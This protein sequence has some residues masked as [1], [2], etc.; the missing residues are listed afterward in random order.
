MLAAI[1]RSRSRCCRKT[2]R[3]GRS[4]ERVVGW[5][6]VAIFDGL[7]GTGGVAHC[8]DVGHPVA[9]GAPDRRNGA[10]EGVNEQEPVAS[11]SPCPPDDPDRARRL[12]WA[13]LLART[14][15]ID[16]LICPRCGGPMRLISII[17]DESVAQRIVRHL[18]LPARP[19]PRG[20]P[21]WRGQQELPLE[22]VVEAE[23]L[24]PPF[25]EADP[26]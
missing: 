7:R 5:V 26:A 18:G 22:P 6:R 1:A 19:P 9:V 24:D 2:W 11:G 25:D 16:V 4:E 17:E 3:V 13:R 12:D 8:E 14:F 20:R 10:L 23:L 21:G 15:S